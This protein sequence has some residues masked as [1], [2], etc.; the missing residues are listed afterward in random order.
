[1]ERLLKV[2]GKVCGVILKSGLSDTSS[3]QMSFEIK[4]KAV[5]NATGVFTDSIL[6]MDDAKAK[7]LVTM[8]M[9]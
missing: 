6:K 3:E 1:M 8:T 2:N 9:Y 7:D 4:A 5:I